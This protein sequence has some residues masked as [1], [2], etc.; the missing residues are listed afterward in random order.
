MVELLR[1]RLGT[2]GEVVTVE[3]KAIRS[4]SHPGKAHCTSQILT[5]YITATGV[6]LGQESIPEKMNKIQ[7]FQEM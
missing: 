6:V 1:E 4:T 3:G 2:T 5:A 7:V